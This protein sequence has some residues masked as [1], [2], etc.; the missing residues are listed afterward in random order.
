MSNSF[1]KQRKNK[2]KQKVLDKR[3]GRKPKVVQLAK[4]LLL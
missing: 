3:G 2:R 1:L 4:V